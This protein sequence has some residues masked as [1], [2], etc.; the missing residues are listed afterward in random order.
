MGHFVPRTP[1]ISSQSPSSVKMQC[2]PSMAM[3]VAVCLVLPWENRY[4]I[5]SP[6]CGVLLSIV[7]V[8]T[9][10]EKSQGKSLIRV[11]L[12]I[13][14]RRL[15]H[16][17]FSGDQPFSR[18]N[19]LSYQKLCRCGTTNLQARGSLWVGLCPSPYFMYTYYHRSEKMQGIFLKI[20]FYF[21][22]FPL[23]I[24]L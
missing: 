15:R 5:L 12:A 19:L 7:K 2:S 9:N 6:T 21:L 24:L 4:M 20:I 23:D 18:A 8:Y 13:T 10:A 17:L 16:S 22:S 3:T 14:V 11:G 1:L